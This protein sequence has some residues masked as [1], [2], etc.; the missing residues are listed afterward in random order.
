MIFVEHPW[1]A[2]QCTKALL[3]LNVK[4][5]LKVKTVACLSYR[6]DN[7]SA[8][9][10]FKLVTNV[11]FCQNVFLNMLMIKVNLAKEKN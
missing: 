5:C 3:C 10:S 11:A 1:C 7:R 4:F 9:F 6:R 2:T 8:Y